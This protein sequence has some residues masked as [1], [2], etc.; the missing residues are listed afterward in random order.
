MYLTCIEIKKKP[1][2]VDLFYCS[3]F[4]IGYWILDGLQ[5]KLKKK[6]HT[7]HVNERFYKA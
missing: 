3:V 5:C 4:D 2:N 6:L 1:N 7:I